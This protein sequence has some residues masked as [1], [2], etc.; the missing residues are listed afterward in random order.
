MPHSSASTLL[1]LGIILIVGFFAGRIA[2]YLRLPRISGY[3]MTG[4][5]LSP[6]IT[7]FFRL[8]D[9]ENLFTFISEMALAI[10]AY[11]IGGS[12]QMSRIRVLGKEILWI[13]LCEGVG[14]FLCSGLA[15]FTLGSLALPDGPEGQNM[16]LPL[17]LILGGISV[18]TAPAAT[19]AVIHEERAKGPLT[20]TLLGVVALDDALSIVIFTA[21][22]TIAGV[23]VGVQMSSGHAL[24]YGFRQIG[25]ALVGGLV[26]GFFLSF[27]LAPGKR[28]EINMLLSLG[29]IFLV[30]GL[31]DLFGF[32]PLLAAMTMA[33]VVTNR[34]PHADDLFNELDIVEETLF[35][36]FFALAAAHFDLAVLRTSITL[37]LVLLAGRFLGKLSGS[38]LG[39]KISQAPPQ[40][41]RYLGITLLPQAGLSLGLIFLARPIL[42]VEFFDIV[43]NAML[44]SIL[45][46]EIISPPLVKWS[47]HK[48]GESMTGGEI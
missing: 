41:S 6:S 23:L 46:N 21:S 19:L 4:L 33:F 22:L 9:I 2:N 28:P 38:Y 12:L 3:I 48:A 15:V 31:A 5:L 47:L 13:N 1:I 32:S 8:N 35:C 40:V 7:G 26:L 45:L 24:L 37:G 25:G 36:L 20:T 17:V 34:V 14:A 10:I 27:F 16:L 42:P 18:A 43:L 11:S 29:S 39:G 44:A 30:S